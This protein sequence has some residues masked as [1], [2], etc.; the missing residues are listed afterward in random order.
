MQKLAEY[1]KNMFD[2]YE[3]NYFATNTF[4]KAL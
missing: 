3:R 4:H 2:V 1:I